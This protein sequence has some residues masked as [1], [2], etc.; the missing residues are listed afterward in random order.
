MPVLGLSGNPVSALVSALIFLRPA[1]RAMLDLPAT[2]TI[3][4]QA[5]LGAAMPANQLRGDYV[6]APLEPGP[7]GKLIPVPFSTQDSAML[8]T[9]PNADGLNR[10]RPPAPPAPHGTC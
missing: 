10:P 8:L 3:F 4:D 5:V 7:D 2:Q 1:M 6:R 9:L